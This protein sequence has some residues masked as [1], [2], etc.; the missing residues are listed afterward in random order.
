MLK[1]IVRFGQIK[2]N[3]RKGKDEERNQER[4]RVG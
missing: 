3:I 4:A 1:L 2:S